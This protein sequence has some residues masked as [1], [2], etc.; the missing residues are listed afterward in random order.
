MKIGE[1]I[2]LFNRDLNFHYPNT[3]IELGLNYAAR[4]ILVNERVNF[5]YDT[6]QGINPDTT[7]TYCGITIKPLERETMEL[8]KKNMEAAE[9]R[10]KQ[11]KAEYDAYIKGV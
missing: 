6:Y 8:A 7:F 1:M 5:G 11:A 10:F 3:E 2:K 4:Q 9:L